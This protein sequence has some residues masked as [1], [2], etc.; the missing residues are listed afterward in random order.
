MNRQAILECLKT[1]DVFDLL[2]VGGGATGCGIAVDAASRGLKVALVEKNDFAE[3][4]SSKSTKLVHGGVRYLEMA[5]KKFDRAQYHLVKEALFER[6]IFLQNA[7]HLS[8]RVPLVTPLYT[9]WEVP[10]VFAG[11]VLYDLLAGKLGLGR[12]CLV[13]RKEALRR[14]PM[15]RGEKLKAGV[16][17]YDGQFHDARMA[18]TLVLTAQEHGAVLANHVEAISFEKKEGRL[19]GA[20]VR[21]LIGGEEFDI[22]ARCLIN[23]AGPFVDRVRQMDDPGAKQLLNAASGI[24]IV[25][26]RRFVPPDTGMLIPKTED[27]RVL[28][29]LPWQKHALIGTTDTPDEIVEHPRPREEE[30]AYLLRHIN[31]Y[32]NLSVQRSDVL[33]AW[34]GLRPLVQFDDS[35]STAQLVREHLLQVSPSG[36]VTM[37]GGKWTSYR[38]MA[39]EAVD[40]AIDSAGLQAPGPCRTLHLR[41]FGAERYVPEIFQVL[42]RDYGLE[43]D[44]AEHL[45]HAFGDQAMNVARLAGEDLSAR[46]HADHPYI[47]AE[48]VYAAR[49]ELAER[50]SDVLARR[51]PLALLDNAAARAALPRVVELLAGERGWDDERRR[52]E[53]EL[54]LERLRISV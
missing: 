37:A 19:C 4:T 44:V 43:A 1:Q 12:S 9:W 28:F 33:S 23:A 51:I 15:L 47:E 42:T 11:L 36:L 53:T 22:R 38:K 7:P 18:I 54:A 48:V 39:E 41:L 13:G 21:D 20:R 31:R 14:F 34:S 50:A 10:Y 49:H 6:G 5:V 32:F 17:Y 16:I 46:L 52:Q 30:I 45:Q 2:I 27:G 29:V 3:G 40:R 26:S 24:H 25:L 35:A 8:G